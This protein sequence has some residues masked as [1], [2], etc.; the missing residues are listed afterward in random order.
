MPWLRSSANKVQ[1]NVHFVF[2]CCLIV[3]YGVALHHTC[4]T[5]VCI[6]PWCLVEC[7]TSTA[8]IQ[9]IGF[10]VTGI[11]FCFSG[12]LISFACVVQGFFWVLLEAV[13]IFLGLLASFHHPRHLKSPVPPPWNHKTMESLE[14][15]HYST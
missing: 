2:C 10:T 15:C 7:K 1:T 11:P 5:I 3:D 6:V 14:G 8:S 4:Y 12:L 13:G 9:S